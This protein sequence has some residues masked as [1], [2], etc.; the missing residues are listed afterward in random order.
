[1]MHNSVMCT[2]NQEWIKISKTSKS[3]FEKWLENEKK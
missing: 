3:P 2:S 1:M